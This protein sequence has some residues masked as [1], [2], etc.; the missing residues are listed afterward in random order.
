MCRRISL[1]E[2]SK[3]LATDAM[4]HSGHNLD[5]LPV[6]VHMKFDFVQ[7]LRK[8]L[9]LDRKAEARNLQCYLVVQYASSKSRIW[10]ERKKCA[11]C[12]HKPCKVLFWRS[13]SQENTRVL[14]CG[15][16]FVRCLKIHTLN[17]PR[18]TGIRRSQLCLWCVE[19]CTTYIQ[20]GSQF[21]DECFD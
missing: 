7:L 1:S 19:S 20:H 3:L 4:N 15:G 16:I 13:F 10:K 2:T 18:W 9:S 12:C 6:A 21:C 14:R 5:H 11:K 17:H 8:V